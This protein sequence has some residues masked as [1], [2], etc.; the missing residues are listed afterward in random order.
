MLSVSEKTQYNIDDD[1]ED[2]DKL[3]DGEMDGD[4]E[5]ND[6]K[7]QQS[8]SSIE[9]NSTKEW[10]Q[11]K[12]STD[13][14]LQ[15]SKLAPIQ[16]SSSSKE[17]D[18]EDIT[19]QP[20]TSK[21]FTESENKLS[22][23]PREKCLL[24]EPAQD[25]LPKLSSYESDEVYS[26]K[27]HTGT[28][29]KASKDSDPQNSE[30][31]LEDC[32]KEAKSEQYYNLPKKQAEKQSLVNEQEPESSM[33][34]HEQDKLS[35]ACEQINSLKEREEEESLFS[36][37]DNDNSKTKS[38]Q[39][40]KEFAFNNTCTSDS[41]EPLG[42]LQAKIRNKNLEKPLAQRRMRRQMQ[43]RRHYSSS[44]DQR[45]DNSVKDPTF[46]IKKKSDLHPSDSSD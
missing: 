46:K 10:A 29:E 44:D 17:P 43:R 27:E 15:H 2:W 26:L 13:F 20:E 4:S 36:K 16:N 35:R 42:N 3:F 23:E 38:Y 22:K 6:L 32:T 24:M 33:K 11:E 31:E 41:D 21:P 9:S 25:N 30:Q 40:S 45:S 7:S 34:E 5:F 8:I 18:V 37:H 39:A 1:V 12:V 28:N 19:L 14:E